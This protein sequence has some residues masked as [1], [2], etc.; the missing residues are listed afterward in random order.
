MK[1]LFIAD[2]HNRT[3]RVR[4][5]LSKIGDQYDQIIQLGD[6]FDDF[7][8]NAE[9]VAATAV[10]IN[11]IV[12]NYPMKLL[13]GN[14]DLPYRYPSKHTWCPGFTLEKQKAIIGTLDKDIWDKFEV[15]IEVDGYVVSHAGFNKY[16]LMLLDAKDSFYTAL[17]AG[18]KHAL[19]AIGEPRGGRDEIGGPLWL[20]WDHEFAPIDDLPQVVGHTPHTRPQW[21]GNSLCLDTHTRHYATLIDGHLEVKEF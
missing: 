4:R 15:F 1:S 13:W 12:K 9:T 11:Y 8:D 7:V 19:L 10:D 17:E 14:H 16:N 2:I 21:K 6:W 18:T 3:K 20:D 5:L